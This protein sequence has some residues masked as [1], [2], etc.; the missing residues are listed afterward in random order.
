MVT[1]IEQTGTGRLATVRLSP[2][3]EKADVLV[4]L[5]FASSGIEPEIVAEATSM[6]LFEI[7]KLPVAGIPH[8]I[9]MKILSESDRRLQDRIDLEKLFGVATNEAIDSA[10]RALALVTKR[11]FARNRRLERNFARFRARFGR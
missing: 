5:L 10:Q 3:R 11:G 8:L 1:A 6:P 4:D 7:S 2:P 9:A